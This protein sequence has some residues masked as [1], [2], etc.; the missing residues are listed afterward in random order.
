MAAGSWRTRLG[1]SRRRPRT[2]AGTRALQDSGVGSAGQHQHQQQPRKEYSLTDPGS[3]S[4]GA[5][6]P[7]VAAGP[8][9]PVVAY[10]G[11]S[12]PVHGGHA[13]PSPDGRQGTSVPSWVLPKGGGPATPGGRAVASS[14]GAG[15][16][17]QFAGVQMST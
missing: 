5:A 4:A 15:L 10:G 2:A 13:P 3:G 8:S 6:A 16:A 7:V 12:S 9:S 1:R 17:G 11:P 14:P